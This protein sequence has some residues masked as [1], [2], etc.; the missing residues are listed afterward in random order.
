LEK[1]H[2]YFIVLSVLI[3]DKSS[4]DEYHMLSFPMSQIWFVYFIDHFGA[5][6][7]E[8]LIENHDPNTN[9]MNISILNHQ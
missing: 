8:F 4:C 2:N 1:K 3:H 5:Q 9:S 6:N 7:A